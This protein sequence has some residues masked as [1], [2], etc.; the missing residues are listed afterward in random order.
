MRGIKIHNFYGSSECGGIAYDASPGP[1]SDGACAGAPMRN[2]QLSIAHDGCL[3]VR[4]KSVGETYWPEPSPN[5]GG[6]AF[7]TTDLAEISYG[8][9]YLRGRASDQINIAGRKVSPEVI[10]KTLLSHPAVGECLVFGAPISNGQRSEVIVAC[11]VSRAALT[12]DALRQFLLD[13][14]PAW[15]IPREWWMV[16]SLDANER[17]KLSRADW[18]RRFLELNSVGENMP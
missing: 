16:D 6:G 8:L 3:E 7:R 12:G 14:L 4:S 17:G 10:E 13:K 2:V 9:V 18:R 11:V 15:Q 5:L 1:R